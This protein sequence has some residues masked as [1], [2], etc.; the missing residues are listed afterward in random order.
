DSVVAALASSGAERGYPPSIG[1]AAF[2][3]AAA[4]WLSRR[5]GVDAD[6]GSVGACIGTK[7]LVAGIPHWLRL[8]RPDLG[9]V[10]YPAASWPSAGRGACLARWRAGPVPVDEPWAT[11]LAAIAPAD[12][13]RALCLWVNTPGNPAGGLDDLDA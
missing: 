2:R 3:E 6:P 1:S 13:E 8:R 10:Q 9:T 4:R 5:V 11:A 7:E 12:A